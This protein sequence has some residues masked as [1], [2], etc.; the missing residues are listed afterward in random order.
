MVRISTKLGQKGQLVIPKVFRDEY[1]MYPGDTI[2]VK[3]EDHK[4]VIEKPKDPVAA[5][6]AIAERIDFRGKLDFRMIKEE[7][8]EERWKKSQPTT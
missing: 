3:E 2:V 8:Y 6:A 5:L 1:H 7:K 4:L